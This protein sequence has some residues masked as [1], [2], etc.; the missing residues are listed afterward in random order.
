MLGVDDLGR[1]SGARIDAA[2]A[3]HQSR[4]RPGFI[5]MV[6]CAF[7]Q[8]PQD[9][10]PSRRS[11]RLRG[12]LVHRGL[13]RHDVA[14]A[15]GAV[16]GEHDLGLAVVDA[17]AQRVG[18]EAAEH[19]AVGRADARAGQHAD[20]DLGH[21]AHVDGDAIALLYAEAAQRGRER[22]DLPV[23][24]AVGEGAVV[25]PGS[26]SQISAGLSLR[27]ARR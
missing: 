20:R 3:S 22:D 19:D 25:S 1:V 21:H 27:V 6:S 9:D 4:S 8:A 23:E 7:A 18:C 10:A 24:L 13:E 26:L 14:A 11:A 15:P 12:R 16:L 5:S 2:T 17:V